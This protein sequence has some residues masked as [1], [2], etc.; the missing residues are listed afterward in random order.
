MIKVGFTENKMLL[1]PPP[2]TP[3]LTDS[4]AGDIIIPP[5]IIAITINTLDIIKCFIKLR[6]VFFI[7]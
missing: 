5:M 6:F 1:V 3:T 7:N 4:F 2:I